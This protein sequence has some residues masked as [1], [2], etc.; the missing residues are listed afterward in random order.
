VPESFIEDQFNLTGLNSQVPFYQE[1]MSLILDGDYGTDPK[2]A[3][4]MNP[5][6]DAMKAVAKVSIM[7][8]LS[9]APINSNL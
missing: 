9:L 3:R 4:D 7:S 2:S 5:S 6:A 1:A 8:L